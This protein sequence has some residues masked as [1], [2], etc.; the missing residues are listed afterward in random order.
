ME[1]T[2]MQNE[3][4]LLLSLREEEDRGKTRTRA[5]TLFGRFGQLANSHT[6][7]IAA[8]QL[9]IQF[10]IALLKK[11]ASLKKVDCNHL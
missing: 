6:V 10:N 11:S 7:V 4:L 2:P 5:T 8:R 9:R 3:L 1:V